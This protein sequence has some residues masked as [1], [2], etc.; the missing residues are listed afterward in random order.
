MSL[1]SFQSNLDCREVNGLM[2]NNGW[3]ECDDSDLLLSRREDP[4][5]GGWQIVTDLSATGERTIIIPEFS[6]K[7]IPNVLRLIEESVATEKWLQLC[8]GEKELFNSFFK[9]KLSSYG[10]FPL[11]DFLAFL[12]SWGDISIVQERE[13]LIHFLYDHFDIEITLCSE[14]E[15]QK[16]NEF[17]NYKSILRTHSKDSSL[18][19][20]FREEV[21]EEEVKLLLGL[22]II[23]QD[24]KREKYT[25]EKYS[26]SD[27]EIILNSL[28]FSTCLVSPRGELVIHNSHFSSLGLYASDCL[29]LEN[30]ET[31]ECN[32][33]FFKVLKTPLRIKGRDYISYIFISDE[34]QTREGG[35]TI[36]SE[37][38]GI[39]S[40]SIAHELNNPIA[41]ILAAL[42]LL[43]LE[44]DLGEESE[45]L[46]SDMETG[47]KRCKKLI[48]VF[49]G[50]SKLDPTN[51]QNDTLESSVEQS[52]QLLRSRMVESNLKMVFDYNKKRPFAR[53]L[54][55][56]ISSMIF[57]LILSEAF[58]LGHHQKLL[59]SEFDQI[60]IEIIEEGSDIQL[61]FHPYMKLFDVIAKSKL[62]LH[63][64]S[65]LELELEGKEN[66]IIIRSLKKL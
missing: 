45:N 63:L 51:S 20:C 3:R 36:S 50:F 21:L 11:N 49:L 40:G 30:N 61:H 42:T 37:E 46:I 13:R 23:Y 17:L 59:S 39:I 64:M 4:R 62:L 57:Y 10:D 22:L 25:L 53:N 18:F 38:L 44:D 29:K 34:S 60:R 54:N 9:T 47:A 27:W 41:G 52:L 26:K 32:E 5:F 58:T 56:S 35:L 33:K 7:Y 2:I 8:E 16:G 65:L 14:E 31:I 48:E 6:F 12:A 1:K 28:S 24:Q 19:F 43:K 15:L 66:K 55:N